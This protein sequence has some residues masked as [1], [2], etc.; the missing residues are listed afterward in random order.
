M[1]FMQIKPEQP[2]LKATWCLGDD[3]KQAPVYNAFF[4]TNNKQ[5]NSVISNFSIFGS[6][7]KKI[8]RIFLNSA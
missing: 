7:L 6:H 2:T 3:E 5:Q 4:E 8:F 1:G